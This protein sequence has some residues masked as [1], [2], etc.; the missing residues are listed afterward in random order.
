MPGVFARGGE[1]I[2]DRIGVLGIERKKFDYGFTV[3]FFM[4][5][6]KIFIVAGAAQGPVPRAPSFR[7]G[8]AW[9]DRA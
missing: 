5:I 6:V 2:N 9:A 8:R 7:R 3:G 4:V 1:A